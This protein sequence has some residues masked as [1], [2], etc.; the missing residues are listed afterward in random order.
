[1][2]QLF[3]LT[4]FIGIGW[5][6]D[7]MLV[8]GLLHLCAAPGPELKTTAD[9]MDGVFTYEVRRDVLAARAHHLILPAKL[10]LHTATISEEDTAEFQHRANSPNE[11][12]D[13][14][15]SY[16]R[17]KG[18]ERSL[19]R[20]NSVPSSNLES[21]S[22]L[23]NRFNNA[24]STLNYDAN[25][26]LHNNKFNSSQV[27]RSSSYLGASPVHLSSANQVA[28]FTSISS[29]IRSVSCNGGNKPSFLASRS[30]SSPEHPNAFNTSLSHVSQ[31]AVTNG[32]ELIDCDEPRRK[33]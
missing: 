12:H 20:H 22:S 26:S 15:A 33:M 5:N 7:I 11:A 30:L 27:S 2:L 25:N 16:G 4:N 6:V 31:E 1:M 29:P 10:S 28:N 21:N 18:F 14:N 17:L 8:T 13:T 23:S 3:L 19:L 32:E 24:S 9:Y